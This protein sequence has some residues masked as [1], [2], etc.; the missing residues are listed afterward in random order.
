MLVF[1]NH[2]YKLTFFPNLAIIILIYFSLYMDFFSGILISYVIFFI[3]GS[4]TALNPSTFALIGVMTFMAAF[5]L[6]KKFSTDNTINEVLITFLSSLIYYITFFLLIYYFFEFKYNFINFL[7]FY[8]F[9][10]SL[11]TSIV[12]PLIFY[13][14]K[15][16]DPSSLRKKKGIIS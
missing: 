7:V 6:W 4:L 9:P 3:Y 15:K 14:F 13:M 10:V 1:S 11:T 8:L 5:Y 16:I 12:S 2:F